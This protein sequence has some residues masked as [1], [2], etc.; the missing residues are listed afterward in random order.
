VP[1]INGKVVV[2]WA[3]LLSPS[4]H[5]LPKSQQ[6]YIGGTSLMIGQQMRVTTKPRKMAQKAGMGM[7]NL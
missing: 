6:K 2:F 7:A 5:R 3:C 1:R 4:P